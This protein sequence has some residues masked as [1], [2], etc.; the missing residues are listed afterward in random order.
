MIKVIYILLFFLFV[1][2]KAISPYKTTTLTG[3][4]KV[5]SLVILQ[6]LSGFYSLTIG[7]PQIFFIV[8]FLCA[9]IKIYADKEVLPLTYKD[10][11]DK[12]YLLV[13]GSIIHFVM[14]Y[15]GGFFN[16]A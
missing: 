3:F 8:G 6:I 15:F 2:A 10:E 4:F 14:L 16:I 5:T 12:P 11:E 7:I 1:I 9:Y 13:V